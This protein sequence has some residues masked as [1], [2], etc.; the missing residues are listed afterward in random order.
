MITA[1]TATKEDS[2]TVGDG[3]VCSVLKMFVSI[4]L[5]EYS[6]GVGWG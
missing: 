1:M 5:Y 4:M 3:V 2:G 6:D